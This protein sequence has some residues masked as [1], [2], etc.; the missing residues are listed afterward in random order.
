MRPC[1]SKSIRLIPLSYAIRTPV[2][3]HQFLRF[4]HAAP[5]PLLSQI[6]YY[7][8]PVLSFQFTAFQILF[9]VRHSVE[10]KRRSESENAHTGLRRRRP[11]HTHIDFYSNFLGKGK[12]HV[13]PKTSSAHIGGLQFMGA[14]R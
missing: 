1:L 2:S 3:C 12:F 11:L 5:K 14:G 6:Y 10:F 13:R 7:L 9:F 4:S 8:L